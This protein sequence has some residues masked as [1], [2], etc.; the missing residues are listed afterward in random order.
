MSAHGLWT[1]HGDGKHIPPT[2]VVAPDERLAWPQTV[3]LGFQH[4]LAMF[5]ATFIVPVLI[6]FPP[7]TTIF[8]SG[9]GTLIFLVVTIGRGQRLGLPSYL[10]SSFAFISPVLV[11]KEHGGIPSALAGILVAGA[12]FFVV[13][14]IVNKWGTRFIEWMMP[15]VV[16]GAVVAL[17]GLNLASSAFNNFNLQPW[18]AFATLCGVVL[19]T[20]L[21]RGFIGRLSILVGVV[22]GYL[23]GCAQHQV[24]FASVKSAAWIGLPHFTGPHFS[25]RP[26]FLIVPVVVVLIAENTGHI[27]AVA[28]MTG[29]NLDRSLGRGYMA[30]GL[31]TMLAG[32]GGGSGTTTYAENIGVMAA[33]KVY[34]TAAYYVAA[35]VAICFGCIPKFGALIA[36]LPAGVLG[37]AGTILYGL[38]AV[39]GGRIWVENRVNFNN[40]V[41]L[42]PCAI[43]LVLGAGNYTLIFDHGNVEFNGIAMGAFGVII[44]YQ[45]MNAIAKRGVFHNGMPALFATTVMPTA[46]QPGPATDTL[47]T[48]PPVPV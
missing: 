18:T 30:D 9:I 44:I 43:G 29:R 39:L 46:D 38:I 23:I 48:E 19:V 28:T 12:V 15:P 4:V 37:G 42:I 31:S 16:T 25:M 26:I 8:F 35:I 22:F 33:T 21:F 36:T 11:A 1:V 32:L 13:G 17:I 14:L 2:E 3:G 20:V 7:N 40:P 34:S 5:G 45:V 41:N 6:G 10:G 47:P 27:K 24:H